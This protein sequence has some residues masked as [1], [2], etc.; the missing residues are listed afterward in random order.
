MFFILSSYLYHS[1]KFKDHS[2][3]NK[4]QRENKDKQSH[5][6]IYKKKK[7][8][9]TRIIYLNYIQLQ[10]PTCGRQYVVLRKQI[11]KGGNENRHCIWII[12]QLV[13]Y[14]IDFQRL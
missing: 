13:H 9:H 7:I 12:S 4:N 5:I 1:E 14:Q 6:T 10:I 11:R 3:K 8:T 2:N